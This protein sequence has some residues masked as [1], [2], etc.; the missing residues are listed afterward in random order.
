[1]SW[2]RKQHAAGTMREGKK[3]KASGSNARK[4]VTSSLHLDST[5]NPAFNAAPVVSL[6]LSDMAGTR[7]NVVRTRV[8]TCSG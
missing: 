1:V 8:S 7:S 5:H 6:Y 3:C 2:R 4:Q